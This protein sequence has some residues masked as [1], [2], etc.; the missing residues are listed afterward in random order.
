MRGAGTNINR[1]MQAGACGEP[2]VA[3]LTQH[4]VEHL[5]D[6]TALLVR[7]HRLVARWPSNPG[8][9]GLDGTEEEG[10]SAAR[11]GRGPRAGPSW[12]ARV[13][14]AQLMVVGPAFA[15]RGV[16]ALRCR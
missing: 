4:P 15:R 3:A 2:A 7:Q 5:P 9:D 16:G 14:A 13:H 1:T 12:A 11:R 6:L 8:H 10:R